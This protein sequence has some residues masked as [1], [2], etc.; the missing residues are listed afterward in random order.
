MPNGDHT[1]GDHRVERDSGHVY[2]VKVLDRK[3]LVVLFLFFF[4]FKI[5][6]MR[7]L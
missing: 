5:I 2:G 7:V 6:N 1:E 4:L 3:L